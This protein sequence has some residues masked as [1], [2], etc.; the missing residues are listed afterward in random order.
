[1]RY[2][3][4][5]QSEP[6][7]LLN[8]LLHLTPND[9]EGFRYRVRLTFRWGTDDESD[10]IARYRRDPEDALKHLL[11]YRP[12]SKFNVGQRI[13]GM[14]KIRDSQW[15]L[16]RVVE[17][18]GVH[19]TADGGMR[20]TSRDIE[21]F[22]PYFGRVILEYKNPP[23][24]QNEVRV[25]STI[26]P[27]I[28]VHEIRATGFGDDGFPGFSDVT[29]SWGKLNEII[30][31]GYE[32]WHTALSN[33]KGIYL[34]VDRSNGAAYVGKAD[35]AQGALWAR[36]TSYART[37]HGGNVELVKLD[38][39]HIKQHFQ[40]SILEVMDW[41]TQDEYVDARESWWKKALSTRGEGGYNRN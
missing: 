17:I 22:R 16:S 15:L 14:I 5:V 13:I 7:I 31:R 35:S 8:D 32:S 6:P 39:A 34:I 29:V 19:D 12:R 33:M 24:A 2:A 25:A 27:E 18:T 21:E 26:F 20:Y 40:W 30:T 36:W 38:P 11:Y 4:G 28:R 10:P 3:H 41:K 9:L 37:C 1:M 23:S